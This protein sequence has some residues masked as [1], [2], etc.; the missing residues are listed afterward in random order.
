MPCTLKWALITRE[1]NPS[2]KVT[3]Q[4][5]QTNTTQ[6]EDVYKHTRLWLQWDACFQCEFPHIVFQGARFKAFAPQSCYWS[7]YLWDTSWI[8]E[9]WL[10]W[11]HWWNPPRISQTKP[12]P[13]HSS[14]LLYLPA[15]IFYS[16]FRKKRLQ[17]L[18]LLTLSPWV[19]QAARAQLKRFF[20]QWHSHPLP[21]LNLLN[22]ETP[23]LEILCSLSFDSSPLLFLLLVVTAILPHPSPSW[24][25]PRA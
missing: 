2:T 13:K 23:A 16:S 17:P 7:K 14:V 1:I 6:A 20:H 8:W 11:S 12:N 4:G 15:P 25:P 18:P 21:H 5:G 9:F 24:S 10:S 3:F 19:L 22:K